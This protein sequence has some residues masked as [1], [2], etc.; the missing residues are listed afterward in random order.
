MLELESCLLL[1]RKNLSESVILLLSG[2]FE[3]TFDNICKCESTDN[4]DQYNSI[5]LL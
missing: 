4:L 2:L 1:S 5:L 3:K